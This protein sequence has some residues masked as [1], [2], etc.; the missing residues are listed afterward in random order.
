VGGDSPG[1]N[2]TELVTQE[3]GTQIADSNE[4]EKRLIL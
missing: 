2:A 1:I 3:F 4:S